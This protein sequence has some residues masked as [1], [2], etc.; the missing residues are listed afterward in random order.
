MR[1]VGAKPRAVLM[2]I[3]A[4]ALIVTLISGAV[5]ILAGSLITFLLLIPEP[6]ISYSTLVSIVGGLLT[7]L[8]FLSISSLY[9]AIR[10]VR[11]PIASELSQRF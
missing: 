11:K 6:V 10:A 2:I 7:V 8:G 1:A 3:L 5:G 4:Q 9:P